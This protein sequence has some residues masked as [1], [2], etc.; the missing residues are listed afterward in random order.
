MRLRRQQC[1]RRH[2]HDGAAPV[3]GLRDGL[4][5]RLRRAR[6]ERQLH[7]APVLADCVV[8]D[9]PSLE[10]GRALLPDDEPVRALPDRHFADVADEQIALAAPGCRDRHAADVLLACGSDDRGDPVY[11]AMGSGNL[12]TAHDVVESSIPAG[13]RMRRGGRVVDGG[14]LENRCGG[15]STGGSNPSPSASLRSRCARAS[16]GKPGVSAFDSR[17]GCR[18]F[19][20]GRRPMP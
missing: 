15:N 12:D 7:V 1:R 2:R 20:P 18:R 8:H 3:V 14:G 9:R 17:E 11:R 13:C 5:E 6:H 4:D 19:E 10:Q 16:A